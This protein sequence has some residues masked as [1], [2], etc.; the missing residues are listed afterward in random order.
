MRTLEEGT[1]MIVVITEMAF[2]RSA[3]RV[4]FMD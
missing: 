2:A 3:D 4:V 1:T